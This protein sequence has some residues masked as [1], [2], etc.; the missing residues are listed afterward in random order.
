MTQED[1]GLQELVGDFVTES[2][3]HLANVESDLLSLEG[4]LRQGGKRP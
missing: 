3:E 2:R 1:P 4:R